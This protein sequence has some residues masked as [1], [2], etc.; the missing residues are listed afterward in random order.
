MEIARRRAGKRYPVPPCLR[1]KAGSPQ[2]R[3]LFARLNPCHRDAKDLLKQLVPVTALLGAEVL[4]DMVASMPYTDQLTYFQHISSVA[5]KF[6][7]A[8]EMGSSG[9]GGTEVHFGEAPRS[10]RPMDRG[11][12][13]SDSN[14]GKTCPP[15]LAASLP[16]PPIAGH[17]YKSTTSSKYPPP[18]PP[19]AT[20]TQ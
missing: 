16:P 5:P 15:P 2:E 9:G 18:P 11:G 7:V 14:R 3:M 6:A 8:V 13:L 10:V 17:S 4:E 19:S 1:V 12:G 20:H